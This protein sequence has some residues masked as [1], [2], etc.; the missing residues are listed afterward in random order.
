MSN[1]EEKGQISVLNELMKMSSYLSKV[2]EQILQIKQ[3][4]ISPELQHLKISET[5]NQINE[6]IK[7]MASLN[8]MLTQNTTLVKVIEQSQGILE[9][10]RKCESLVKEIINSLTRIN[11]IIKQPS[12][13][14][15]ELKMELDAISCRHDILIRVLLGQIEFLE[16]EL[17]KREEEIKRLRELLEER[18][19]KLKNQYVT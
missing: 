10:I 12:L 18:R 9:A 7:F 8:D 16:L 19:K 5:L 15:P 17:A 11:N 3:A 6:S 2:A 1:D 13:A 14:F 4:I